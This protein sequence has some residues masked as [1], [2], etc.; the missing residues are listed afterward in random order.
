MK[1]ARNDQTQHAEPFKASLKEMPEVD[2]SMSCVHKNHHA[3]RI[4]SVRCPEMLIVTTPS[5][6][7]MRAA[8]LK[9][10][11][12]LFGMNFFRRPILAATSANA[13]RRQDSDRNPPPFGRD[14][15][16][17][18]L[19]WRRDTR[20]FGMPPQDVPQVRRHADALPVLCL[21]RVH[22]L[23][24]RCRTTDQDHPLGP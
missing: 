14:E 5:R 19:L 16:L 6:F 1:K 23:A 13:L 21:R 2:L 10:R 17:R 8:S 7:A 24:K 9:V 15:K 4:L 11:R 3:A 22:D 12:R 18:V 20:T